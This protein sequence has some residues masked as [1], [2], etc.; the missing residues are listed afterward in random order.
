MLP[1]ARISPPPCGEGLG[2]G[3]G[4]R[5]VTADDGT[6]DVLAEDDL[7]TPPIPPHKGEGVARFTRLIISQR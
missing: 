6:A 3:V 7:S 4:R 2:V 5:R 1:N